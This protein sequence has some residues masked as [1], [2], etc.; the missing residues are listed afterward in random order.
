LTATN[1]QEVSGDRKEKTCYGNESISLDPSPKILNEVKEVTNSDDDDDNDPNLLL[2]L[3]SVHRSY[4]ND[5]TKFNGIVENVNEKKID[6][7]DNDDDDD[8]DGD[9][10]DD[11]EF[12]SYWQILQSGH[13]YEDELDHSTKNTMYIE[14]EENVDRDNG[15]YYPK[16]KVLPKEKKMQGKICDTT[17]DDEAIYTRRNAEAMRD[18]AN[19]LAPGDYGNQKVALLIYLNIF[20]R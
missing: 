5:A 11:D 4:E 1:Q 14:A 12:R 7:E 16:V 15:E 20:H 18:F 6:D 3:E 9:G 19:S 10:G 13:L 2:F 17:S 8:D